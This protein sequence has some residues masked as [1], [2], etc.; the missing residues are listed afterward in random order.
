MSLDEKSEEWYRKYSR[1]HPWVHDI[2]GKYGLDLSLYNLSRETST[3]AEPANRAH[4]IEDTHFLKTFDEYVRERLPHDFSNVLEVGPGSWTYVSALAAF[5]KKYNSEVPILGIDNNPLSVEY[6]R[7][8]I[9]NRNVKGANVTLWDVGKWP[10]QRDIVINLCS[11]LTDTGDV[12]IDV[13]KRQPT[14]DYVHN[15][16]KATS[17]DGLLI[18]GLTSERPS[19]KHM[20]T[21]LTSHFKDIDINENKYSTDKSTYPILYLITAKPKLPTELTQS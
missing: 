19:D 6:S 12:F 9:E 3:F 14:I 21:F 11:N 17:E 18:L 20:Q 2:I 10:W 13:W 4:L 7:K 16:W 5:F 1:K 15:L 8:S